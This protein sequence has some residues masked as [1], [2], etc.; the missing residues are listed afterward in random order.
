M[1]S[2]QPPDHYLVWRQSI[3]EDFSVCKWMNGRRLRE[4]HSKER[5]AAV[6]W[7]GP[8]Q[9]PPFEPGRDLSVRLQRREA[10]LFESFLAMSHHALV[11]PE[12]AELVRLDFVLLGLGV[13]HI[14][15]ARA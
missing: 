4:I 7:S 14:S 2:G 1:Q 9:P 10:D 3:R 13:I 15:L 8:S 11:V 6:L 5:A 12:V